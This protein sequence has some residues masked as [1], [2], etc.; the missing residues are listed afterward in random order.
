MG[1]S[2]SSWC[3]R[4]SQ[5]QDTAPAAL[6]AQP[7]VRMRHNARANLDDAFQIRRDRLRRRDVPLVALGREVMLIVYLGH[8]PLRA[9]HTHGSCALPTISSRL[10]G[11]DPPRALQ[12]QSYAQSSF[13]FGCSLRGLF[14]NSALWEMNQHRHVPPYSTA[15]GGP[16][17]SGEQVRKSPYIRSYPR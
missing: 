12:T 6:H 14:V 17:L 7:K 10:D 1:R 8:T 2:R 5:C 15:G 16:S 11:Y 4:K 3:Q 13:F 9:V